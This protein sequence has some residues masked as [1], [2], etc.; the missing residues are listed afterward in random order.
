MQLDDLN[1]HQI[2]S[3]FKKALVCRL[4]LVDDGQPYLVPV[5]FGY[6]DRRLFF[7]SGAGGKKLGILEL[8]P[9]VCFEMETDVA[10][11]PDASPCR[12]SMSYRSV[13]GFGKAVLL[14]D[15]YDKRR[16]L[17]AVI[18][19]YGGVPGDYSLESLAGVEVYAIE[20]DTMTYK[21]HRIQEGK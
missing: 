6:Q 8:N 11:L 5:C 20:I 12:F 13:I 18:R 19:Q 10:V 4:A 14:D 3:V 15:E 2:E 21:Q 17:D 1:F 16:G 9:Q 7:H